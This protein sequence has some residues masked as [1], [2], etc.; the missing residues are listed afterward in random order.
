MQYACTL[1]PCFPGKT[2]Q[3]FRVVNICTC[4]AHSV[5]FSTPRQCSEFS[6]SQNET[7]YHLHIYINTFNVV[8]WKSANHIWGTVLDLKWQHHIMHN[9]T[10]QFPCSPKMNNPDPAA[11]LQKFILVLRCF[12]RNRNKIWDC[13]SYYWAFLWPYVLTGRRKETIRQLIASFYLK[14]VL[15]EG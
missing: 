2:D 3:F 8:Y 4:R 11:G 14:T 7:L 10:R 9:Q 13:S 15:R 1:K 6:T 12:Y 5:P